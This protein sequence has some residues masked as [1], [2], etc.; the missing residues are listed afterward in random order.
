ML[1]EFLETLAKQAVAAAGPQHK[2][3]DPTKKY[4]VHD[5][6]SGQTTFI[7]G[8]VPWRKHKA[9]DLET[10]AA[11]ADRFQGTGTETNASNGASIWCS[12]S[13]VI[14]LTDDSDRRERVTV[15]MIPSDQI[16]ALANLDDKKPMQAQRDI[17]FMLR[18]VFTENALTKF[19][20]L[21]SMLR[22]VN[23]TAGSQ[24]EADI[25]RGKASLGKSVTAEAKFAGGD[26]PE[27]IS[28]NVPVFDNNFARRTY[29]VICAL[30]IYEAE[31]KF[32]LFPLP[33]EVEK[34]YAQA[35]AAL[36]SDILA[37]LGKDSPVPVYYGTP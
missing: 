29:D 35:E 19:P 4:V 9:Q 1:K 23:F 32:Q 25:Q 10:I 2:E 31:Q 18:T 37:L 33:G 27:Q 12:R 13:N 7:G 26:I 28:L 36:A 21:I 20:Q 3:I 24:A 5:Q 8:E 30:E 15:E 17:L 11:F 34:A 16:V 22:K 14:L 6:A